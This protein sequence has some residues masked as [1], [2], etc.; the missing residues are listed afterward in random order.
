MNEL[1]QRLA[2]AKAHGYIDVRLRNRLEFGEYSD[3]Y[4]ECLEY[5]ERDEWGMNGP[6]WGRRVPDYLSDLNSIREIEEI[7][8]E[9]QWN[10][11]AH[12]LF[13]ITH[14]FDDCGSFES[15]VRFTTHATA[16][17]KVEALLKTL[18]LWE[19]S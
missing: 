3:D 13:D 17:Q 11:Y 9:E 10:D 1:K 16:A 14:A 8:T 18:N 2:L 6:C 5:R 4:F 15:I 12:K 19:E 7:L